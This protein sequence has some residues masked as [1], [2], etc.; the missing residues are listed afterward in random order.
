MSANALTAIEIVETVARAF[1]TG[2]CPALPDL[3]DPLSAATYVTDKDGTVTHFNDACIALA[4]RRPVAGHDKWCVTWRIYTPEGQFLPH[5]QCPMAQAINERRCVRGV[6]AVA[7]RPDGSW[8]SFMPYPTPLFDE[9]GILVGAI[10]VLVEVTQ[11]RKP[12]YL[13][14]QASRC[15]RLAAGLVDQQAKRALQ[16]MELQY[17]EQAVRMA[18]FH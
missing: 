17:E 1:A 8:A 3:I 4:G 10:N 2:P 12:G 16:A 18:R 7:Q 14:S 15:R 5:D 11:K 6:E 9:E 13:R